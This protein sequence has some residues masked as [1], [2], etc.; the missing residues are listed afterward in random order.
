M[1]ALLLGYY[2]AKNLGDDLM[3]YCLLKW[4]SA[5]S[6]SV[7]VISEDPQD[8]R[9]RFN[10]P[11]V[12]NVPLFGEW[13]CFSTWVKGK[14]WPLLAALWKTNALIVGGGDLIRDDLGWRVFFYTVEKLIVACILRKKIFLANTGIGKPRTGYGRALLKILLKKCEKI[15][16]RDERSAK[17]CQ[18]FGIENS[19]LFPDIVTFFS[20]FYP[21]FSAEPKPDFL[22]I[23]PYLVVCLR[24]NAGEY[25]RL[26]NAA[27]LI[28]NLAR[29]LDEYVAKTS[30]SLVFVPFQ[31]TNENDDN[32]LHK[33]VVEE[34][35]AKDVTQILEWPDNFEKVVQVFYNCEGVFAMR[36]H[37]LILGLNFRKQCVALPYDVKSDELCKEFRIP[38][39]IENR[40]EDSLSHDIMPLLALLRKYMPKQIPQNPWNSCMLIYSQIR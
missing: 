32:E 23:E 11:T 4:L 24:A 16:V 26:G 25:G 35:K 9:N 12:R 3:L 38:E 6:I 8:T 28:K 17:L 20:D 27:Q 18:T 37:A 40:P 19:L 22:P 5:Q 31:S 2:G 10:I 21:T 29:L 15:I 36:L 7:T 13:S 39:V 33:K 30:H 14:A 34:M 1:K